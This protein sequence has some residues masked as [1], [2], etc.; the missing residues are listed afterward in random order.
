MLRASIPQESIATNPA[1]LRAVVEKAE[2]LR[3]AS[4]VVG[5]SRNDCDDSMR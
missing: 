4:I 5:D 1:V 3:P 2:S